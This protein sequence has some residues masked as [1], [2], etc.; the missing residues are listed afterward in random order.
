MNTEEINRI[1][2][3]GLTL[4]HE[5]QLAKSA[6]K[7]EIILPEVEKFSEQY[8]KILEHLGMIYLDLEDEV[9]TNRILNLIEEHN[10]QEMSKECVT[11]KCHLEK[12]TLF[13]NKGNS[14][15]ARLEFNKAL[16]YAT[17]E[18]EETDIYLS[19]AS[20]L[21]TQNDFLHSAE[22]YSLAAEN[23]RRNM[24]GPDQ[25]AD[26][27]IKSAVSF[28]LAREY[29]K[30]NAIYRQLSESASS[31]NSKHKR[32]V[33][34][35]LGRNY[36][37]LKNYPEAISSYK[38]LIS[39]LESDG[40]TS[41]IEYAKGIQALA[42]AE[43]L[44]GNF[45]ESISDYQRCISLFENLEKYD[46]AR[47]ARNSMKLINAHAKKEL[48]PYSDDEG[49]DEK[50]KKINDDKLRDIIKSE[51]FILNS[52]KGIMGKVS[53]ARSL[54]TIAGCYAELE[55]YEPAL[56]Y[57][58]DYIR[59][60]R[61]ALSEDFILKSP[62]DRELSW[63]RDLENIQNLK[64]LITL[65]PQ[66]PTLY[67]A[68]SN[69]I[70]EGELISK[71]ILLSSNTEFEKIIKNSG[72]DKLKKEYADIKKNLAK[73]EDLRNSEV[74]ISDILRLTRETDAMQISLAE[75][76][77]QY[78]DFMNFLKISASDVL[79]ALQDDEAAIEFATV[80]TYD[81]LTGDILLA[82][83]LNKTFPNGIAIPIAPVKMITELSEKEDLFSNDNYGKLIWETILNNHPHIRK[84]FFA[85]TGILNNIG[86]EYLSVAGKPISD[87]MDLVRLSSTRELARK[88]DPVT[89]KEATLVGNIDYYGDKELID[90]SSNPVIASLPEDNMDY[91]FPDLP[92]SAEEISKIGELITRQSKHSPCILSECLA[93]KE[94]F[95]KIQNS[96]VNILHVAT[97]GKYLDSNGTDSDAMQRSFLAMSG[98]NMYPKLSKNP[99]IVS[100][101]EIAEMNLNNCGLV[102]LSACE[103]GLGKL[104][105][106]GVFGLQR[107]FKNAGVKTL[108]VS[109]K[110]VSDY[111]TSN[112]MIRFYSHLTEKENTPISEAFKLAQSDIR[113]EFP[114]DDTWAYFILIDP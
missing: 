29:D 62:R 7:F 26:V 68:I 111:I 91:E 13:Y 97:H 89:L 66:S 98:A 71:G 104:G 23:L 39:Q 78:A 24:A 80:R 74:D 60:I 31:L 27:L 35:G 101:D 109:L 105:S 51:L 52:S 87:Q 22:Y 16:E 75:K 18:A 34:N 70:F 42:S 86:I 17:T 93:T 12:A 58:A 32:D 56:N 55:E 110:E 30:S 57:Y 8:E 99:C 19:M 21:F 3:E 14:A 67:G 112:F 81:I 76:S 79:N 83:L 1:L 72:S 107:G 108:L 4:Y 100:A 94:N 11:P 15:E 106:D 95:L 73:I 48:V 61:P 103:S 45:E 82:V 50:A 113:K 114:S 90:V 44:N 69:L 63:Q 59:E 49:E 65:I 25:Y 33:L 41:D 92:N 77:K 84:I 38:Q 36:H 88:H 43:K 54:A 28:Y 6:E 46:E 20:F 64:E 5:N 85:P 47:N 2:K 10:Q 102:V 96:P 37:A 9:N 53:D 40:M